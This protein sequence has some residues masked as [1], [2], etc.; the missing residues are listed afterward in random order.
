MGNRVTFTFHAILSFSVMQSPPA[1]SISNSALRYHQNFDPLKNECLLQLNSQPYLTWT[2][3]IA[4]CKVK[5]N[6]ESIVQY[7][8]YC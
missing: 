5:L 7:L 4:S 6:V 3:L 2:S 8:R 1:M